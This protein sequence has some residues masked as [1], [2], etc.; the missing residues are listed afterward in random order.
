[1]NWLKKDKY[2]SCSDCLMF[3]APP[4]FFLR[5]TEVNS[6]KSRAQGSCRAS[7]SPYIISSF[8][9]NKLPRCL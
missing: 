2:F 5:K 9:S 8:I 3:L 7:N 6:F 4:G 1:M